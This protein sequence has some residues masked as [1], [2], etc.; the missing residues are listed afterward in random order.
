MS[1]KHHL[2]DLQSNHNHLLSLFCHCWGRGVGWRLHCDEREKKEDEEQEKDD[3]VIPL[4][5]E[6]SMLAIALIPFLF[7][8][9]T[10]RKKTVCGSALNSTCWSWCML[11]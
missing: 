10:G 7:S 1:S 8:P 9:C 5:I 6:A 2:F 11:V 3:V 4:D